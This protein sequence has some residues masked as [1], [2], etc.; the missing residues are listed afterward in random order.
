L[1]AAACDRTERAT[2]RNRARH[3]RPSRLYRA[4]RGQPADLALAPREL[5]YGETAQEAVDGFL[6]F[7]AS[8]EGK[9]LEQLKGH[10]TQVI[11]PDVKAFRDTMGR[12]YEKYEAIWTRGLREKLQT[13]KA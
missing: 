9:M 6:S 11:E 4:S 5:Q 8:D 10:G 13:Y 7:L 1:L 3:G 2:E 12:V